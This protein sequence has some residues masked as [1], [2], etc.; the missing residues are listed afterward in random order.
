MDRNAEFR[1]SDPGAN[2]QQDPSPREYLRCYGLPTPPDVRY[3]S[4]HFSSP[5]PKAR[6]SIFG[7]AWLPHGAEATVLFLHGF[8]EHTGN[9]GHLIQDFVRAGLAVAAIDLRGH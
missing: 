8:C 5:Q 1:L 7:Q 9:Y 3:G 2:L 4:L 6:V